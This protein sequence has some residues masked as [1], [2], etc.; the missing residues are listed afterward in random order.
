MQAVF[1]HLRVSRQWVHASSQILGQLSSIHHVPCLPARTHSL[2]Q[3]S[4]SGTE[5]VTVCIEPDT[6]VEAA[7]AAALAKAGRAP[8]PAEVQLVSENMVF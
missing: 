2:N 3:F 1:R 5:G 7:V 4:T 6:D 8:G